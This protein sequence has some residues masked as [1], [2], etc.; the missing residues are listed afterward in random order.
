MF[1]FHPSRG[2]AAS[3]ELINVVMFSQPPTMIIPTK[4]I[5]PDVKLQIWDA[6]ILGLQ[7]LGTIKLFKPGSIIISNRFCGPTFKGHE[8]YTVGTLAQYFSG[9]IQVT[10]KKPTPMDEKMAIV[11]WKDWFRLGDGENA[12]S[13]PHRHSPRPN[14]DPNGFAG[15]KFET[16]HLSWGNALY[17]S[18]F[19]SGPKWEKLD[20]RWVFTGLLP[21]Q[22]YACALWTPLADPAAGVG[23]TKTSFIWSLINYPTFC[24]LGLVH[25]LVLTWSISAEIIERPKWV[26]LISSPVSELTRMVENMSLP[27]QFFDTTQNSIARS[28]RVGLKI[29]ETK[30]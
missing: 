24:D 8:G 23:L 20:G 2:T 7:M 13:N 19:V 29:E 15:E 3:F 27:P 17:S 22:K 21:S 25:I 4:K 11:A 12:R 1:P 30:I 28:T 5:D 10:I 6:R 9:L 16:L 18:C 26:C 14:W